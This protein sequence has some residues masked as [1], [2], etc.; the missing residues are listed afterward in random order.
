MGILEDL[1]HKAEQL[2]DKARE[3]LDKAGDLV[4]DVRDRVGQHDGEGDDA[5][6]DDLETGTAPLGESEDVGPDSSSTDAVQPGYVTGEDEDEDLLDADVASQGDDLE[7]ADAEVAE[8]AEVAQETADGVLDPVATT[9]TDAA[10]PLDPADPADSPDPAGPGGSTGS[11]GAGDAADAGDEFE[12]AVETEVDPYTQPLSEPIGD[13]LD[14]A[15]QEALAEVV[16]TSPT[17]RDA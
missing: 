16:D 1:K 6:G 5:D 12:P 10:D 8:D 13:V 15:D 2:A 4:G 9:E 17:D 14:P 11:A 3:G 7:A